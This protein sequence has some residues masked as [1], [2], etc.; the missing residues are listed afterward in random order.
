MVRTAALVLVALCT[1]AVSAPASPLPPQ[2]TAQD[3]EQATTAQDVTVLDLDEPARTNLTSK[4][5]DV[6]TAVAF[7]RERADAELRRR[8][9]A[10]AFDRTADEQE[11]REF[12]LGAA[13]D[14]EISISAL[15]SAERDL[16]ASYL[17]GE[18]T[19][20]TF[21]S[22]LVVLTARSAQLSQ[23]IEELRTLADEV[24]RFSMNSR[25]QSME[26]SLTG[27][28]GPVRTRVGESIVGAE[29]PVRLY[30][31][32]SANGT[33]FSILD[34]SE[35]VREGFRADNWAPDSSNNIGLDEVE[36][37]AGEIY[38]TAFNSSQTRSRGIGIVTTGI[39]RI[40]VSYE[41][42]TIV[43][44]LDGN[45]RDVFYEVQRR[46]LDQLRAGPPVTT[47]ENGTRLT[48]NQTFAGG[49]L[50]ISAVDAVTGEP[51]DAT[52]EVAGV[53]R[54]TG[55][56]GVVWVLM[57]PDEARVTAT[58]SQGTTT[59][60]VDTLS[61]STVAAMQSMEAGRASASPGSRTPTEP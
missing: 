6:S 16:W 60:E 37:R 3:V 38:P 55:P 39:Y 47:V 29:P 31:S 17:A 41:Q 13:T 12:L 58:T 25:L 34:G 48:V 24:P 42:G 51:A 53:E 33:A 30:A 61:P 46:D 8:S 54:Q 5:L 44:Y 26:A 43:A 52:V 7:Q 35:Y 27:F 21:L 32:A 57:P 4:S 2:P 28:D 14:V 15:R 20:T 19:T 49:P 22:R 45:T 56:T 36:V 50:R 59:L 9:L 18:M 23:D 1:L 11:R 40:E 10:V